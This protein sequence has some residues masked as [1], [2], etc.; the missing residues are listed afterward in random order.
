MTDNAKAAIKLMKQTLGAIVKDP[1]ERPNLKQKIE[2]CQAL[3]RII[4]RETNEQTKT[5]S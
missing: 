3:L 1:R 5:H 4:E 2:E